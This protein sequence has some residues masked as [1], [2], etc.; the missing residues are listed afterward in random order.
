MELCSNASSQLDFSSASLCVGDWY[1]CFESTCPE[2]KG[3]CAQ[4]VF[5]LS[6]RMPVAK[7]WVRGERHLELSR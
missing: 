2:A 6:I 4:L 5:D 7:G 1:Q 3:P